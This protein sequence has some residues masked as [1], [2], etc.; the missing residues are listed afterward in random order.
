MTGGA[1]RIGLG[2]GKALQSAGAQ[3]AIGDIDGDQAAARP[4]S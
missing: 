3:V 1:F 4:L 2:T